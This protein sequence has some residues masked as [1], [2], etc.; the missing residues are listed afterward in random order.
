MKEKAE[1]APQNYDHSHQSPSSDLSWPPWRH[2]AAR[3][4]GLANAC[5]R[6]SCL[7][8]YHPY[9]SGHEQSQSTRGLKPTSCVLLLR[10]GERHSGRRAE[11][12]RWG[13]RPRGGQAK[14]T[15]QCAR[16]PRRPLHART[17]APHLQHRAAVPGKKLARAHQTALRSLSPQLRSCLVCAKV[18]HKVY[19]GGARAMGAGEKVHKAAAP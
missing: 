16:G 14:R 1:D 3:V 11:A 2:P 13:R 19:S 18:R 8:P 6:P 10:L 12:H 9:L 5:I 15:A 4:S 7:H 17:D